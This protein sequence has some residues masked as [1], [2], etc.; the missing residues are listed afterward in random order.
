[1]ET[2]YLGKKLKHLQDIRTKWEIKFTIIGSYAKEKQAWEDNL[3]LFKNPLS[4]TS[5]ESVDCVFEGIN[6]TAT[7]SRIYD[8]V[9]L[10]NLLY[11]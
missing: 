6:D 1:M 9:E 11:L 4:L 7:L 10:L 2:E 5:I 3:A 8:D